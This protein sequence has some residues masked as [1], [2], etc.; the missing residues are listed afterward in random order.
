MLIMYV[1]LIK[2]TTKMGTKP[3]FLS[4][5][6]SMGYLYNLTHF[7]YTQAHT[8][9]LTY[10]LFPDYIIIQTENYICQIDELV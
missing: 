9:I 8:L 2:G 4:V 6:Q 7:L 10:N 3:H 5:S 1:V